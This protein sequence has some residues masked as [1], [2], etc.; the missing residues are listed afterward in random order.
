MKYYLFAIILPLLAACE[1]S[2]LT[3]DLDRSGKELQITVHFYKNQKDLNTALDAA[4]ENWKRKKGLIGQ[5]VWSPDD[6]KCVIYALQP[7]TVDDSNTKTLGHE[8]L[9]CIYGTY[10]M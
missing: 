4:R 2:S 1:R 5:A 7:R 3:G 6:N 10:H 8:M 9:H